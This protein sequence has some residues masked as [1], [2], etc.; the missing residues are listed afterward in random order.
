MTNF[1][2][3]LRQY[4]LLPTLALFLCLFLGINAKAA[5]GGKVYVTVEKFTLGQG[6]LVE[7]TEVEIAE[8]EKASSV[9]EKVLKANGYQYS[10]Y[11]EVWYLAGIKNADSGTVKVPSCIQSKWGSNLS[12]KSGKDLF[13]Y[14]YS[15]Q[16]GWMY[17]VN[18]ESPSVSAD[19]Y[20]LKNGDVVRLCFTLYGWGG[21]LG[22][23]YDKYLVLPNMDTLIKRMAIFNANKAICV[24]KG[25][26]TAYNEALA[27][28]KNMD[29]YVIKDDKSNQSQMTAKI[30]NAYNKLPSDETVVQLKAEKAAA[31]AAAKAA[32]AQK[33]LK[34]TPK[35][36]TLKTVKSKKTRTATLTWNK[37]KKATGYVIYMSTK[38][39]SGYKKI[40]TIKK[41]NKITYTKK[42]LK[43]NKKYYFKL[44]AYKTVSGKKYYSAYSNVKKVKVK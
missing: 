16:S 42:K 24:E 26:Q 6:Y 7:P 38:K 15:S 33:I 12:C 11:D 44:K 23:E 22:C 27:L 20:T 5:T 40:T 30:Q 39:S 19:G 21:D 37:N 2:K 43:K 36:P 10:L 17:F 41:W 18:N 35:A 13:Q 8:G 31:K 9:L 28:A 25:Y 1:N 3:V 34:Y 32:E 4:L 14:D 29:A